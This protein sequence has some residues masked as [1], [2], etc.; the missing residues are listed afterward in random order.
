MVS[1]VLPKD[2]ACI[3]VVNP[4]TCWYDNSGHHVTGSVKVLLVFE[5][6]RF[7]NTAGIDIAFDSCCLSSL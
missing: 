5:F 7:L 1:Q 4:C 3:I 2:Q 6:W